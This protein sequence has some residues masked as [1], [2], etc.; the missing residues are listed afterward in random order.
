MSFKT[1][2][3]LWKKLK[4]EDENTKGWKQGTTIDDSLLCVCFF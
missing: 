2:P 4:D 3:K 1:F